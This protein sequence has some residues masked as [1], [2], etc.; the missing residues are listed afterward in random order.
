M[1]EKNARVTTKEEGTVEDKNIAVIDFK[2]YIDGN[3]FEGGEG[4]DFSL[5]IG[6]GSFIDN[7]EEQLKGLAVE[8]QRK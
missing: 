4:K 2:G 5:E 6:S 3:A 7:F 1:Q 8:I